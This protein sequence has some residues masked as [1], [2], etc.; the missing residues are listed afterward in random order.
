M[1]D[2]YSL[3]EII[4][5]DR[6]RDG[7]YDRYPVRFFSM[8]YEVGVSNALIKIRQQLKDI[9]LFDIKDLLPHEDA[10]ITVDRFRNAIY[11]L[12]A[13]KSYI[14]IG[15]S[16]YARFLSQ[17]EFISLL[18]SLVELENS[19]SNPK[20]RIYMPCFALYSQIQK[21]IK[22][23]HRRIDVYNPL[24]NDADVEELPRIYFIDERLNANYNTNEVVNSAEWFGMW[25]NQDIDTNKPILCSSKTLAYFYTLAS[26]DN[27]Y[28]IQLIKSYLDVLR[29]MYNIDQIH[30]YK[31]D[32]DKYISRLISLISN[33]KGQNLRTVILAAVNTQS[34]DSNNIYNLWKSTDV[35]KR[36]LIQNYI[37]LEANS[38]SYLYM[39]MAKLEELSEEEFVE[40]IYEYA[41]KCNE[42]SVLPERNKILASIYRVEKEIH[43]TKKMVAFYEKY[44]KNIIRR[45][46]TISLSIID[47][48]KDEEVIIAKSPILSETLYDEFAQNLTHFSKNERQLIIWLY[49]N[50]L[51]ST[52]QIKIHYPELYAYLGLRKS[53]AEPED[54]VEQFDNYFKNYRMLRLFQT[55]C[56]PYSKELYA[57]NRDE[58]SFYKWYL[59]SEIEYPDIFLKKNNFQGNIY[60]LDA[61]G[62]EFIPFILSELDNNGFIIEAKAYGKAHLPTITSVAKRYYTMKNEWIYDYDTNVI[63]GETYYHVQN[64]ERSLAIIKKMINDICAGEGEDEF[65]IIADHGSTVG[66]KIEKKDKKYSFEKSEHDGRCFCNIEKQHIGHS[67]DYVI[68]DDES[69]KEWVI[70]LT[71]QSLNN[72]SKFAVH[73]GATLEEVLVPMV[74]AHKGRRTVKAFKVQA[75]NLNVS[76]LHK[77]VEF[78]VKPNPREEKVILKAKDGTDVEMSYKE[79]T[80]TWI[81]RLKRGIEQDIVVSVGNKSYRFRTVP[82]TKMGDDLF[83]D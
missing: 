15:F 6:E 1:L 4:K 35:F 38:N 76:G 68:Y 62:A 61:V 14:V 41:L 54:Y 70:A 19:D 71:Q 45:K 27:V 22:A 12:G 64:M 8:K 11:S 47:F 51:L 48:T 36:W 63:H 52:S 32:S 37:L 82:P 81:G 30:I 74:I 7:S 60:V 42:S 9:D 31:K 2:I 83:D 24:L 20:R 72:N 18:I 55:D 40:V 33:S 39:V 53:D 75:V 57:W 67:E 3:V 58:N 34:I 66:H 21:I 23:Y 79:D 28:N 65:A 16:E 25:R 46:T 49:R 78:I 10:W 43:F 73:G 77:D 69:G 80:K 26:P 56:K 44:L 5:N 13:E 50:K 59:D 17:K 29:Y